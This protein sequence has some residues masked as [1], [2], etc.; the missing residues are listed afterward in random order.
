M[1]LFIKIIYINTILWNCFFYIK[2]KCY[3]DFKKK[4]IV[5]RTLWAEINAHKQ[6]MGQK[7]WGHD[8]LSEQEQLKYSAH[9]IVPS[10]MAMSKTSAQDLKTSFASKVF[11]ERSLNLYSIKLKLSSRKKNQKSPHWCAGTSMSSFSMKISCSQTFLSW[12]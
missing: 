11:V 9:A 8:R 3:K 7:L 5:S 10:C 6:S 12:L 2:K 4:Q 1:C